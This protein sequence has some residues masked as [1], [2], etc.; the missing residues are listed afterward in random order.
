MAGETA[1]PWS[2]QQAWVEAL[3]GILDPFAPYHHRRSRSQIHRSLSPLAWLPQRSIVARTDAAVSPWWPN[4]TGSSD[5]VVDL[6]LRASKAGR[7]R[8]VLIAT[9]AFGLPEPGPAMPGSEVTIPHAV[10]L[11]QAE[12]ELSHVALWEMRGIIGREKGPSGVWG[13]AGF[14][15]QSPS[16]GSRERERFE[17]SCFGVREAWM[18]ARGSWTAGECRSA[19][20]GESHPS[21]IACCSS[22][23][24]VSTIDRTAGSADV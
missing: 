14:R 2:F 6:L 4:W 23:V 20:S 3:R 17:E 18:L 24:G 5:F 1:S 9:F 16:S 12:C 19:C 13:F 21:S 15:L 8:W 11:R 7:Q 10:G 22:G